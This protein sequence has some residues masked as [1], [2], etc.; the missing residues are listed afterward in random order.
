MLAVV[1]RVFDHPHA[2]HDLQLDE[3]Q[4]S[5]EINA[6]GEVGILGTGG[7]VGGSGAIRLTFKR[8][9]NSAPA[10]AE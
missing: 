10:P 8:N 9:A 2:L 4:L 7:S 1:E 5:V 3:V 6:K